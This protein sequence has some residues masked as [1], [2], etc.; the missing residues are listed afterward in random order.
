MQIRANFLRNFGELRFCEFQPGVRQRHVS[1]FLDGNQMDV[2][3]RNLQPD[4]HHSDTTAGQGTFNCLGHFA[5]KKN[6]SGQAIVVQ[7]KNM[8]VSSLGT[9][10]VWPSAIGLISRK[11]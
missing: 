3:M 11:A 8:S 6:Q 7:I 4:D 5:G 2:C 9:T 10:S 1:L